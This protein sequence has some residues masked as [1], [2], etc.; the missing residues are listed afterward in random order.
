LS[1]WSPQQAFAESDVARGRK[2]YQTWCFGCH[3]DEETVQ[4]V[5]PPLVGLFGRRAGTVEGSPYSRNL[6]AAN[7]VWNEESLQRYLASPT[8]EVHGT[9]MPIGVRD[10]GER[11]DIIAYLK[12][13]K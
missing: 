11:D 7:I 4:S 13:L 2:A 9:I 8:D 1:I 12:T 5:G 3:G 10:P 6:Y